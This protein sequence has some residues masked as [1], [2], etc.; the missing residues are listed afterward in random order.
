M[1]ERVTGPAVQPIT[2][3]ECKAQLRIEGA[4]EDTYLAALIAAAVSYVDATGLL[5]RAIITQTWRQGGSPLNRLALRLPTVQSLSAVKYYDRDNVL[6]TATLS[7][8]RLIASRDWAYV[9]PVGS[10]PSTFDRPD[11]VQ[12]EFVAGYGDAAS[13][14]PES[15]RHA[16]ILLVAHWFEN[17][18]PELVGLTSKSLPH[19]FDA[20]VMAERVSFY[21]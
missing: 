12:V 8:F 2:L 7:D 16:L 14:V 19:S 9:E 11:A 1:L 20:L 13:D 17:R 15:V 18:E 4:D 6:Q 10:W 21:G 3:A 5:G